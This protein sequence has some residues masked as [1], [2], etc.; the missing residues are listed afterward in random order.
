MKY[1][2][3][4]IL[5]FFHVS[6]IHAECIEGDCANGQGSY[7][8]PSGEKYVGEFKDY[9]RSGK[10]TYTW[11]NGQKYVGE[12]KDDKMNGQGTLTFSDGQKYIGEFRNDKKKWPRYVYTILMA[13]SILVNLEMI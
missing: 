5:V 13:G 8:W 3:I 9:K 4:A 7:I 2:I 12:F 6:T 1:V 11:P 10:G